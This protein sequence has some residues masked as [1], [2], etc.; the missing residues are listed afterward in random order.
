MVK[1]NMAECG[2]LLECNL[3][4]YNISSQLYPHMRKNTSI[5]TLPVSN[6]PTRTSPGYNGN[7]S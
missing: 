1:R 2:A 4:F 5:S 6:I 7:G 3:N